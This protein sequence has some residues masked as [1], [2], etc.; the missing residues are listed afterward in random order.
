M[1]TKILAAYNLGADQLLVRGTVDGV[2]DPDGNLIV[3][4]ARGW[5]SATT[6]YYPPASYN[7]DGTLKSGATA[8]AMTAAERLAY[9]RQLV[10]AAAPAAPVDFGISG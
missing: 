9:A 6:N 10:Q 4:E 7:P 5:V 1:A 3:I 2:T 8:R